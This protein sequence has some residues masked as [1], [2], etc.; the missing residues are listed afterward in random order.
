MRRDRGSAD[1]LG[2]VLIAPV[3]IGLAVLVVSLGRGVEARAQLR[4][5]AE[6]G[7]QAAALERTPLAARRAGEEVV[8]AMLTNPDTCSDPTVTIDLDDFRAGGV[9]GVSV[10]CSVSNRG[11]EVVQPSSNEQAVVAY[12]TIDFFRGQP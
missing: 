9:V 10:R 3:V 1:A 11:V 7:A 6:S 2:L 12:A 8:M 5:A 4:S